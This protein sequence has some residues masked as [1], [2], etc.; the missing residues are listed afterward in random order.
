MCQADSP[1]K[2]IKFGVDYE[3]FDIGL[4]YKHSASIN[5]GLMIKNVYRLSR[6]DGFH[7]GI[8]EVDPGY[9]FKLPR[10]ITLG[11]SFKKNNITWLIDNE[12]IFGEYGGTGHKKAEFWIIRSGIE[13]KTRGK[14]TFRAGVIIPVIARTSTTGDLRKNIPFPK[15]SGSLGIGMTFKLFTIDLAVYGDP[16]QSYAKQKPQ[17]QCLSSLIFKI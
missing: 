12:T 8:E 1:D 11:Y 7:S 2:P 9:S 10:Y 4:L 5:I 3:T 15:M 17:I 16:G 6:P 14:F 13:K